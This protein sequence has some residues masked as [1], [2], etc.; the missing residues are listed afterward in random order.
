[1]GANIHML[2]EV[3]AIDTK[4]K[5]LT[6]KDLKNGKIFYENYDKL[7]YAAGSWPISVPGVPEESMKFE[8]VM[9]CKLFQHA[10]ELINKADEPGINSIVII[11]AGYIGI[12]L[13]EAYYMKGKNVTLID[14]DKR[15]IS[16]YFDHE[17]TNPLEEDIRNAGIK[18][19]LGEKVINFEG[20]NNKANKVIT[21][22]NSYLAD[23]IIVCVGFKPNT[24]LLPEAEKTANGAII[25]DSQMRTN[26][27]DVWAIGDSAAMLHASTGRHTQV[28]LATNAVK[29]GIAAASSI[30]GIAG[31]EI[32]NVAG[33]NAIHVF[34]NNLAST[35]L[36]EQTASALGIEAESVYVE[37][38]DR[39]EFMQNYT[40]TKFKITYEKGTLRLLGAQ[41][42]TKGAVNHS[43][44]IYFLALAIQKHMNLLEIAFT[45]VYFL[46]HFNKPFNFVLSAILK[47]AGINYDKVRR[48]S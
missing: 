48:K 5:E 29:S 35:G 12:E 28:A 20:E 21:D 43:E 15:V 19:A 24:E 25:V 9:L 42:G 8:N 38:A 33:T 37:D 26:I 27:P 10:Q 40:I 23:L 6:V 14:Y 17:F 11:G 2:H 32:H 34:D 22:K 18:L 41:I 30:N 46:P 36:T 16:K 13:A 31:V 3:I 4:T 45:D 47:A 7:V 39:P 44:V 1:M